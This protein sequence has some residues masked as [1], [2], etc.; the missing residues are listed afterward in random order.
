MSLRKTIQFLFVAILCLVAINPAEAATNT[1]DLTVEDYTAVATPVYNR[2]DNKVYYLG[3]SDPENE[4][5]QEFAL[6]AVDLTTE[7]YEKISDFNTDGFRVWDTSVPNIVLKYYKE[8]IYIYQDIADAYSLVA[9]N[10]EDGSTEIIN[11]EEEFDP[12]AKIIGAVVHKGKYKIHLNVDNT[13]ENYNIVYFKKKNGDWKEKI[14]PYNKKFYKGPASV[15]VHKGKV[16]FK[17]YN[18]PSR[19]YS[20]KNGEIKRNKKAEKYLRGH[21]NRKQKVGKKYYSAK[22]NTLRKA[23]RKNK[24]KKISDVNVC[25]TAVSTK[26][27]LLV[28]TTNGDWIYINKN[29]DGERKQLVQDLWSDSYTLSTDCM[30]PVRIGQAVGVVMKAGKELESGHISYSYKLIL[31]EDGNTWYVKDTDKKHNPKITVID[32]KVISDDSIYPLSNLQEVQITTD[33]I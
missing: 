28:P 1:S 18:F 3:I 6:I 30:D 14:L 8:N 24:W 15:N 13:T 9:I 25:N 12:A 27:E 21:L 20:I 5:E 10:S 16:Y 7:E 26:K 32:G 2:V 33:T 31:S 29:G 19:I 4:V 17:M 22:T 11:I 23:T